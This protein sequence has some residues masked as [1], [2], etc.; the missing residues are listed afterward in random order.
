M[1]YDTFIFDLDDTLS[2]SK[3]PITKEM[4]GALCELLSVA[5]VCIIT[6]GTLHQINIQVVENL[7]CTQY[8]HNL[9]LQPTS[10]GSL[11]VWN[12]DKKNWEEKYNSNLPAE[13]FEKVREVFSRIL[14]KYADVLDI[15]EKLYGP[16]IQDRGSQVSFSALGQD[17]PGDLKKVWDPDRKKRLAILEEIKQALPQLGVRI[18]GGTTIDISF[19]GRDKAYGIT[20]LYEHT[21]GS[22]EKGIFIGDSMFPGG[23]DYAA[24]KTAINTEET[25]GHETTLTLIKKYLAEA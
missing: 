11:H 6:G 14:P 17:A 13:T 8:F 25:A 2:A 18:G 19:E 3:A 9:Y 4:S 22:I 21:G 23:N 16:Q 20:K 7:P 5:D 1:K 24:T 10:G 12:S 15:P